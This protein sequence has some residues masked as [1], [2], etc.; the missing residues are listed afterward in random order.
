M[1][2]I[3]VEKTVE[4]MWGEF[5]EIYPTLIRYDPPKIVLCNRLTRTIGKCYYWENRIHLSNKHLMKHK[6]KMLSDVIPHELAHQIDYNL[7]PDSLPDNPHGLT[8][9]EIMLS[10]GLFP[11]LTYNIKL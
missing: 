8:W 3:Q 6:R 5:A 11:H 10:Y 9:A 4:I 7:N 2:L 1:K